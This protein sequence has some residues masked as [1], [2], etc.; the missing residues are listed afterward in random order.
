MPLADFYNTLPMPSEDA[1]EYWIRLNKTVDVANECLRRQGRKIDDPAHE[2]SMMFVKHCP[3]QTLSHVFKFKS[4]DKWTASEIQERLDE[5]LQEKKSRAAI[6]KPQ[7]P[8]S[9]V[10]KAQSQCVPKVDGAP[11]TSE[12]QPQMQSSPSAAPTP[13]SGVDADCMRSLEEDKKYTAFTTPLGLH[14]YNRM[15]QGLCNRKS[16]VVADALSRVPFARLLSEP[17]SSLIQEADEIVG[18]RVLVANKGERGKR[19]LADKWEDKVYTVVDA[20]PNIHVYK[21]SDVDG[22]TKVVHRNLLL[23]VNFLPLPD[24]QTVGDMEFSLL[25]DDMDSTNDASA[26]FMPNET[27]IVQISPDR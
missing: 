27:E 25:S 17:Y 22:R 15:A 3:D 23:N 14:E 2:V 20:N 1:M 12:V 13:V 16:N 18:D 11:N 5:N 9:S 24:N 8:T 6:A 10:Y 26:I 19:K 7:K 4:A 21:I